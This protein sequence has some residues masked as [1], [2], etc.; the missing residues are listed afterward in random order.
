MYLKERR[1]TAL[2]A[3][4]ISSTSSENYFSYNIFITAVNL[5]FDFFIAC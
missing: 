1:F 3:Q 5:T 2:R 4:S